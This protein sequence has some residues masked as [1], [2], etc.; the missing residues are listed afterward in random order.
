MLHRA[1][2]PRAGAGTSAELPQVHTAP[3]R[4]WGAVRTR[5]TSGKGCRISPPAKKGWS[6]GA[7]QKKEPLPTPAPEFSPQVHQR[8]RKGNFSQKVPKG[9]QIAGLSQAP[10]LP[11]PALRGAVI[12]VV[13]GVSF[14]PLQPSHLPA[15]PSPACPGGPDTSWMV[16]DKTLCC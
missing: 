8:G 5:G 12:E 7:R 6:L 3:A 10:R 2:S 11:S 13:A 15:G 16:Q 1:P 14:P 9:K 4:W